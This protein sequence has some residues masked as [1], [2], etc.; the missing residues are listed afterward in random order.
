MVALN[1]LVLSILQG[2]RLTLATQTKTSTLAA[3]NACNSDE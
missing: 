1:S 2:K 3:M